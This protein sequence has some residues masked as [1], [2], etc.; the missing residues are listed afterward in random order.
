MDF[1]LIYP[2]TTFVYIHLI[3]ALLNPKEDTFNLFSNERILIGEK[4]V[5]KIEMFVQEIQWLGQHENRR[6][7]FQL[8]PGEVEK[9]VIF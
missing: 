7:K 5:Y 3:Q 9:S 1:I 8:L 4:S 2:R 6:R